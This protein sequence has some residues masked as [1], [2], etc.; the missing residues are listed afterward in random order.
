MAC[1]VIATGC[2]ATNDMPPLPV[3]P[4][5]FEARCADPAV[6][7]CVGFDSATEV[8]PFLYP[9]YGTTEKRGQVVTD[10][11]ASGAGSLRFEIRP[12]TGSDTS[13]SY[14]QNFSDD[15]SVQFGEGEEF[16]V[17]WRQRFS[18][19]FLNTSFRGGGGWKQ[20]IVGEGDRPG[21]RVYSCTQLEIVVQNTYQRGFAQLYH[22]CGGKDGQYQGL[23]NSRAVSYRPQQWM[24]FQLQVRIGHWYRND[25]R[26]RRDS[27]V[28]L[29]VAEEGGRSKLAVDGTNY[30]LANNESAARY[31]KVWLLPY[32]SGKDPSQRHPIGY[33]WYDEL[34]VSRARIADPA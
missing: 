13:G 14:W 11:K 1:S 21:V 27:T 23:D 12:G 26:Y 31:G 28:R 9:I 6:V 34:V 33:T 17:Q 2:A 3:A 25:R 4:L 7:K 29:W 8:D 10:T 16:F 30:D 18:R 22:S 15:L 19:E 32:H 20:A 5:T 24:T